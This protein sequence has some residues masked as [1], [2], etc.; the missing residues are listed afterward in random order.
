MIL[1]GENLFFDKKALSAASLTSDV[2]HIGAG[3]AGCPLFVVLSV[4]DGSEG[5][6]FSSIEL[7]TS[8]TEDFASPV[9]LGTFSNK[10][11]LSAPV[12][13]GNLGY[14]RL[15]AVSK[16]TA[17]TVTAGLALEDDILAD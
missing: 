14:L 15:V 3:E 17:G 7:Q 12:P 2:L 4:K 8:E 1:D 16:Y 11:A 9:T 13:R 10:T 5:G 6:T